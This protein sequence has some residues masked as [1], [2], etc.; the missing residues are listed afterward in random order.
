M[1]S[2][3]THSLA[4]RGLSFKVRAATLRVT[5]GPDTGRTAKVDQPTFVV[6]VGDSADFRLTDPSISR[7]QAASVLRYGLEGIER[8]LAS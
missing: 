8:E 5:Q 3:V 2:P 1:S 7:E 6:G 4:S